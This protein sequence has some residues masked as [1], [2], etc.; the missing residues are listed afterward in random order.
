MG[1]ATIAHAPAPDELL[2]DSLVVPLANAQI[3]SAAL[4][5]RLDVSAMQ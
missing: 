3:E 1:A 4:S 5:A 2:V